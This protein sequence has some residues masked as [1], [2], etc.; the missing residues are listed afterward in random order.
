MELDE[1]SYQK[2]DIQPYWVAVHAR[3]K[4]EIKKDEK[5]QN[6]ISWLICLE[7][8][9]SRLMMF[10]HIWGWHISSDGTYDFT[11]SGNKQ[12]ITN[13]LWMQN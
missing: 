6:H 2:S 1:E 10:K 8:P 7:G 11:D 12:E 4:N 9:I 5:C 13:K 3:L